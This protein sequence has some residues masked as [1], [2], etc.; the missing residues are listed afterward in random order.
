MRTKVIL[1][2]ENE[3]RE[4]NP[5]GDRPNERHFVHGW[6]Y[7]EAMASWD[8]AESRLKTYCTDKPYPAE[9]IGR[10]VEVELIEYTGPVSDSRLNPN[11][12]I[13]QQYTAVIK[14]IAGREY[15]EQNDESIEQTTD[16]PAS[17][18]EDD[19][20][21]EISSGYR[22]YRNKHTGEWI[23]KAQYDMMTTPM[24]TD[25]DMM[26]WEKWLRDETILDGAPKRL[27]KGKRVTTEDLLKEYKITKGITD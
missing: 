23:Y 11:N 25:A 5:V 18:N 14:L 6:K 22:G 26:D 2:K 8:D 3:V 1:I 16:K 4:I 20:I 9:L 27:Y 24:W 17:F 13:N 10:I 21:P 7:V 19:W 12:H 15:T